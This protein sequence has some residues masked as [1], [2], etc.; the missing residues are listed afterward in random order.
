MPFYEFFC[1]NCNTIFT[2]FSR[3]VNTETV[4]DCPSCKKRKLERR[5]SLFAVSGRAKK[6]DTED[7]G[8]TGADYLPIDEARMTK[9][10]EALAGEAEHL[11][12][13]DPRQAANLMR[14]FSDMTGLNYTDKMNEALNRLETGEDPEAIEA[15]MGDSLE[16]EDPFVLPEKKENVKSSAPR[17]KPLRRDETVYEL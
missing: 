6:G 10:M 11:S 8:G 4:P 9:A 17:K 12:E 3:R 15:E 14:K 13:D 7:S 16:N 2:F 1:P 5:I